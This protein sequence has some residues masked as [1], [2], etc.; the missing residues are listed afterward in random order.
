MAIDS[1]SGDSSTTP[2]LHRRLPDSIKLKSFLWTEL[3]GAIGDLR[4]YIPITLALVMFNNLN[5]TALHNISTGLLFG[6]PMP[7]QPMKSIAAVAMSS[8]HPLTVPRSS[9]P[10]SWSA[11]PR[12]CSPTSTNGA[13][14]SS[15]P[16]SKWRE[17]RGGAK[18][19]PCRFVSLPR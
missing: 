10:S 6:L 5:L 18:A 12:R 14:C 8:P 13:R 19:A 7:V 17:P 2:H 9:P 4:T 3:S 16:N 11:P 15:G 1:I